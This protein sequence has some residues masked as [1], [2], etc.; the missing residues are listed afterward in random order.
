MNIN[1]PDIF[2]KAEFNTLMLS[3]AITGWVLF[4]FFPEN[5]Y[6][7]GIAVLCTAYCAIRFCVFLYNKIHQC[8]LKN[9]E[10][11]ER[12]EMQQLAAEEKKKQE[13]MRKKHAQFIFDRLN[14]DNKAA[15]QNI[16]LNGRKSTYPN[17]YLL[18]YTPESMLLVSPIQSSLFYD[19]EFAKWVTI[20]NNQE[21]WII[22]IQEPL[23]SIIVNSI[24]G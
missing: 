22:T 15:L 5:I 2:K 14:D 4:V 24:K 11:K 16:V 19:D 18:R 8:V 6:V 10:R 20:D 7:T 17:K 23:N 3:G 1:I 13:E 21:T 9:Y 12:I